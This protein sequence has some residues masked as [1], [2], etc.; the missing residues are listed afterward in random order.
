VLAGA[1]FQAAR[2]GRPVEETMRLLS[3][4]IDRAGFELVAG[5]ADPWAGLMA[6]IVLHWSGRLARAAELT[7]VVLDRARA[8]NSSMVFAE[9]LA[10][11]ANTYWRSGL[12][13]EAEADARQALAT[14]GFLLGT[15]SPVAVAALANVLVDR[16][17][18]AAARELIRESGALSG[19]GD[20]TVQ[21]FVLTPL[22][23]AEIALGR[24]DDALTHLLQAGE[25]STAVGV[26]NPAVSEWRLHAAEALLGLRRVD[27]AREMLAPAS[28]AARR[29]GGPIEMGTSLRVEALAERPVNL[30]LLGQAQRLLAASEVQLEHARVLV[31]L[32]T[33]LRRVG[34]RTEARARLAEAMELANR[35]G[36]TGLVARAR[37]ELQATG[38]RPRRLDRYGVDALTPSEQRV[39]RFV[40]EGMSN[41]EVA[42]HLFVSTRT[43][44]AQL[45]SAYAKLGISSRQAL[46]EALGKAR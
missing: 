42:Q 41:R 10:S 37:G 44:E 29:S 33:A 14:E 19:V 7:G 28:V 4:L 9:A 21:E 16:G 40:A 25:I 12:I 30:D 20:L 36:A 32:G 35:C 1:A 38:A 26:V 17:E 3:P 8:E 13:A 39:A 43:V 23:R 24:F 6:I 22:G 15:K 45:R 5:P 18:A 27:E 31:D 46:P 34:A 11:R 2:A